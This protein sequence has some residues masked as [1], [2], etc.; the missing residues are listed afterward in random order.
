MG[1]VEEV[2]IYIGRNEEKG[3]VLGLLTMFVMGRVGFV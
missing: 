3:P 2:M 1:T